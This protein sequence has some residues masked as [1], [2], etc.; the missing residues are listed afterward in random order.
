[1]KRSMRQNAGWR[2]L[3]VD[4]ITDNPTQGEKEANGSKASSKEGDLK[5]EYEIV[6]KDASL[7][8]KV[9]K[10]IW[11]KSKLE[12]SKLRDIWCVYSLWSWLLIY[13]M[14]TGISRQII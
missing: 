4:L 1:M 12:K 9:V 7:D 8:G 5:E 6:E 13:I 2:G 11:Q 3:S 10:M 14:Q